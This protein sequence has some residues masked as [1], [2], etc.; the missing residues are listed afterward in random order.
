MGKQ[1]RSIKNCQECQSMVTP[2]CEGIVYKKNKNTE[3]YS[4]MK[5]Q[6][7]PATKLKKAKNWTNHIN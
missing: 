3:E 7:S 1:T 5:T 4:S 2:S 6:T